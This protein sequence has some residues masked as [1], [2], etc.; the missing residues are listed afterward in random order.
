MLRLYDYAASA[1]CLKVRLLFAQLGLEYERVPVDIFAGEAS[2]PEFLALNPAGRTP[3]L[4]L[5][6]GEALPESNAIVLYLAEGTR[7]L[8]FD[9]LGRARVLQWL[10]FEQ[11]LFEPNV[12]SARFWRLTGRAEQRPDVFR[13]FLEVGGSALEALE[14]HL[15]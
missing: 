3:V 13:R 11:N 5:E 15:R 1:N 7:F 8:P 14:R 10:F 2:T 9:R 12:G 6:T 4:K